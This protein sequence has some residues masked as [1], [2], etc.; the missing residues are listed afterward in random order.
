MILSTKRTLICTFLLWVF[1][2][3]FAQSRQAIDSLHRRLAEASDD[4]TRINAEIRLCLLHRLGNTDSSIFYGQRA[5]E[6]ANNLHYVPGQIQALSFMCI[7]TEQQG[8]LPRSLEM[9]FEALRLADETK[10]QYLAG[11][12]LDGI[13]EAYIVLKDYPQA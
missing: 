6:A 1:N 4:T 8:N 5:L 13:G 11:P 9:G 12:A 10:M 7:A 2:V 3:C